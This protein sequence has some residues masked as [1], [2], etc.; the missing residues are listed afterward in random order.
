M[1]WIQGFRDKVVLVTGASSGIGRATA[2][3]FAAAGARVAL[4]ARRREVLVCE[5]E[6]RKDEAREPTR[7]SATWPIPDFLPD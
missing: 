6:Q 3:A 1:A 5:R 7:P 2:L 4:V